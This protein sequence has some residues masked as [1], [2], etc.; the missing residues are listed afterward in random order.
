M[1]IILD[2]ETVAIEGA[3]ALIESVSAP[4]TYKDPEKIAA[5][6]ANAER[7]QAERAAVYPWTARIVA[8]GTIDERGV[9]RVDVCRDEA[10]EAEAL[11][12]FWRLV[13]RDDERF[14]HCLVGFNHRA[15][16]LPLLMARSTLL[17]VK[18]PSLNLDRYRTPH[19]DLMDRLTWYGAVPARS[20]NWFARRFGLPIDDTVSGK[21]VALLVAN[22]KWDTVAA[23]CL[24][25]IRLT[26]ALAERVGLL[27]GGKA[28]A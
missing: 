22:G 12:R 3:G 16:D 6:I 8:L 28:A 21:D 4:A 10:E 20:L 1:A 25:D 11:N 19:I 9:E 15:F 7:A 18:H 14:V 26:K 24:S 17:G 5:Y 23:H 2:T 13:I 27:R